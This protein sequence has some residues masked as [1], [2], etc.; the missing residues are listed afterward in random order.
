MKAVIGQRST[1]DGRDRWVDPEQRL[2][3]PRRGPMYAASC[4]ARQVVEECGARCPEAVGRPKDGG[5]GR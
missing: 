1:V 5:G 3:C 4:V 2:M